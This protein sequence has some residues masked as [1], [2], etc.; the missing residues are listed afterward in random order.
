MVLLLKIKQQLELNLRELNGPYP[1]HW[2]EFL[3]Y[4]KHYNI[5]SILDLGCGVGAYYKL[6]Q[7]NFP[8]V[9]YVGMDYAFEAVD[10]AKKHWEY[11]EFYQKDL[12]DLNQKDLEPYDLVHIGALLDILP[13]GNEALSYILSLSPK[14]V[15]VSRM[16]IYHNAENEVPTTYTAYDTITTYKYK[17]KLDNIL[18]IIGKYDYSYSLEGQSKKNLYLQK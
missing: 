4:V 17:H 16:E 13:N 14:S 7:D 1:N 5:K 11:K 15:L 2:K 6:L 3:E 12:W 10:L 9:K 18:Q 8:E